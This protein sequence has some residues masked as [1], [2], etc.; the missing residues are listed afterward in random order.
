[1]GTS[2]HGG[3]A[4][5]PERVHMPGAYVWKKVLEPVSPHIGAPFGDLGRGVRLLGNLPWMKGATGW[6][7]SLQ[8]GSLRRASKEGSFTRYPGL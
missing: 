2:F 8:R 4:E 5:K 6:G 7:V 1:M 3:L